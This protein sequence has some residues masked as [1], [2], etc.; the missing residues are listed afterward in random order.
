M[1]SSI[2]SSCATEGNNNPTFEYYP[3]R[4]APIALPILLR[5]LPANLYPLTWLLPS[6]MLISFTWVD[7]LTYTM[8]GMIFIQTNLGTELFDKETNTEYPLKDV[9]NAVRTYP[10]SGASVLLPMTPANNW[11]RSMLFELGTSI[12][13]LVFRP[14]PSYSVEALICNLTSGVPATLS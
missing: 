9:P 6:G 12:S 11:V 8:A 14:Q 3:S 4:G 1:S 2:D 7:S 10:A 13:S 5:T